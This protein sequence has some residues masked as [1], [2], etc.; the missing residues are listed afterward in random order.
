MDSR[1]TEVLTPKIASQEVFH[2]SLWRCEVSH[3]VSRSSIGRAVQSYNR[4]HQPEELTA[5]QQDLLPLLPPK[6]VAWSSGKCAK[7]IRHQAC[8]RV[9]LPCDTDHQM[10]KRKYRLTV[11]KL[12]SGDLASFLCIRESAVQTL[13]NFRSSKKDK[14]LANI[15][16][17]TPATAVRST[18]SG[19]G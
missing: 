11:V 7:P 14:Q 17:A 10:S 4:S 16:Q 6:S 19:K 15:S 3:Q 12:S 8:N 18:S 5:C 9:E 13:K 2:Y 1:P